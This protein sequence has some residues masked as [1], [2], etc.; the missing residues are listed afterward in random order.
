MLISHLFMSMWSFIRIFLCFELIVRHFFHSWLSCFSIMR[1]KKNKGKIIYVV[2]GRHKVSIILPSSLRSLAPLHQKAPVPPSTSQNRI[3]LQT[4]NADTGL[5]CQTGPFK[6]SDF[7]QPLHWMPLFPGSPTS[8][9]P[10]LLPTSQS[11]TCSDRHLYVSFM[12]KLE[13]SSTF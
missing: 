4:H 3:P 13:I 8:K 6:G 1:F 11:R 9:A 12:P 2:K 7:Y 5:F 10:V